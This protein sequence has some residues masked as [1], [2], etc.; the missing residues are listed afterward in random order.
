[1]QNYLETNLGKN[2]PENAKLV[3]EPNENMLDCDFAVYT[4]KGKTVIYAP[5]ASFLEAALKKY[6]DEGEFGR[7]ASYT[8]DK[9]YYSDFGAVGDGVA[10]DVDALRRTH[11]YANLRKRHTV[12]GRAGE[13][14]YIEKTGVNP[15]KIETDCNWEGVEFIIDDRFID[16][17][18]QTKLERLTPVFVLVA[19]STVTYTK[20]DDPLGIIARLNERGGISTSDT[21][22][23]LNLGF[24]A[25]ICPINTEKSMYK[26]WGPNGKS[27]PGKPQQEVVLVKADNSID[28][29][30]RPLFPYAGV[31]KII[32]ARCDNPT[33]TIKGGRLTTIATR[34]DM[35]WN[36][37]V[38][39]FRI[40]RSNVIIDGI[41]HYVENQP[42]GE[43][44]NKLLSG[45]EVPI[46]VTSGGGP[47]YQGFFYTYMAHNVL[48]QNSKLCGR[49]H[50]NNGSYDIGGSLSNKTVF[51]NCN[52][53]NMYDE[54]GELYNENHAYWG[55]HGTNY[56]KNIEF[57]DCEFF[58]FDAHAGVYN[59]LISGC[60]LAK[61][62][63]NGG[64]TLL[65]E[66]STIYS[67]SL[68]GLRE[69]YATSWRGDVIF[70]NVVFDRRGN[71]NYA[72]RNCLR[73]VGGNIHNADYGFNTQVPNVIIDNVSWTEACETNDVYIFGLGRDKSFY[74]ETAEKKNEILPAERVIIKNQRPGFEITKISHDD[75]KDLVKEVIYE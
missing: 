40:N 19:E 35:H 18:E 43:P 22:L 62:N 2:L 37:V 24:D 54:N 9:I 72:W 69:D 25:L 59:V 38:R 11:D 30:T 15:V 53:Y 28:L 17:S 3:C 48:I 32:V 33:I 16:E 75:S 57:I 36:Y 74:D 23:P 41:D 52:Q 4:E 47:N 64:G 46:P 73:L 26:R 21:H 8:T 42:I 56:C 10:E 44:I 50:Y 20:D 31:D 55:I 14:Y 39:T 68:I 66:N 58:R 51:K 63:T 6:L 65:I 60:T 7:D 12:C 71:S 70:R 27:G 45:Y 13:K 5:I 49:A 61:V 34:C 29:S 1:M 67:P